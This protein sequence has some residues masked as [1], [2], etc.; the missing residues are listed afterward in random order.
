MK[1]IMKIFIFIFFS[2]SLFWSCEKLED[3]RGEFLEEGNIV[4]AVKPD[5][6]QVFGGR[7]RV[8]IK[9]LL[10]NAA[11]VNKCVVEWQN[12]T[13]VREFDISPSL[14]LDSVEIM[15]DGLEE[16]SYLFKVYNLDSEGNRS[17][18]IQATGTT[19][20]DIYQSSLINR[21]VKSILGGNL[22]DSVA[23]SW[24]Q[25]PQ[26]YAGIEISY[27]N[28]D[29]EAVTRTIPHGE[30]MTVLRNWEP[31]GVMSYKT[32][33]KP[34]VN[35]VDTFLTESETV[36]LPDK[37]SFNA[38]KLDNTDWVI[39][40]Q[41]S[42]I[43]G[44]EAENTIDGNIET[45]WHTDYTAAG[46]DYPHHFVIDMTNQAIV[47]KVVLYRR[48]SND[49]TMA[50]KIEIQTSVDNVTWTSQGSFSYDS[51]ETSREI[52]L[53]ARPVARY[54]KY[55][56]L[57]GTLTFTSLAEIEIYGQEQVSKS[58]W[59]VIDQDSFA[60]GYEADK[61]IDGDISTIWHTNWDAGASGYPHYF[62][63]DM[64]ETVAIGA[65]V[66][67]IRQGYTDGATLVR[68]ETST[69]GTNWVPGDS[70]TLDPT[71]N[72]PQGLVLSGSPEA[73]YFKYVALEGGANFTHLA[74]LDIIG[75]IK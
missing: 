48:T 1:N 28:A 19:Y 20:G 25:A 7:N 62:V 24:G 47:S 56:A 54:V 11:K 39:T 5:T 13:E 74:E 53:T 10:F 18:K 34:E 44:Y 23:I 65:F 43:S 38:I 17:I 14:P 40:E 64:N 52:L 36:Q 51:E 8:K 22:V 27:N 35:A 70:F 6:V 12:G 75:E 29:G 60:Y 45:I 33:F 71:N 59:L 61:A 32:I 57:E 67:V 3:I 50:T 31:L 66:C 68:L 9:Y 37:I 72:S 69:D 42:S 63:V 2:S 30:E 41:N 73:R 26:G 21:P 15:L 4:Y 49:G 46:P 58:Q 55:I 16:K